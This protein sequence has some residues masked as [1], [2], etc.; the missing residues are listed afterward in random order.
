MVTVREFRKMG[1]PALIHRSAMVWFVTLLTFGSGLVNL[2]SVM[3]PALPER[4]AFLR[5]VFPLLFLHISR[6]MSLLVGFSL[7]IS[8]MNIYKR[9]KL[10]FQIVLI[11]S[12]FSIFFHLAKG[13]DYEEALFSAVLIAMLLFTRNEFTVKSGILDIHGNLLKL[14]FAGIIA[15]CYGIVGF[16]L[17]D[18]KEFGI[19][20]TLLDSIRR[21]FLFFAI[22]GDPSIHPHTHHAR[23]FLDSLYTIT[24]AFLVY[25]VVQVFRPVVYRYRTFP[26]EQAAAKSIVGRFGR[27]SQDFFKHWPDKSFFFSTNLEAFIA[28]R[29][30]GRYALALGD[31]VGPEEEMEGIIRSF[32]AMCRDNDWK[33]AFHQ[34][35]PDFLDTYRMLGFRKL[36][37]G[38]EAIVELSET[39]LHEHLMKKF[40]HVISRLEKKHIHAVYYPPP[41]P[42]DILDGAR[43]VSDEWLGIQGRRERGFTL[44]LFDPDYVRSTPVFTVADESE[45]IQAFANI[46]PSYRKG[47]TTIDLMRRREHAPGGVMDFLFVK[48]FLLSAGQGFERFTMGMAPMTGF[49]EREEATA[50]ERAIHTFFQHLNFIF[51]Y[52]G[53]RSYKAKFAAYWEPRYLIYQNALDLPGLALALNDISTVK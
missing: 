13:L 24:A 28:Y 6:L 35:L 26:L 25:A 43:E 11:L 14:T 45:R 52:R 50:E 17:L 41:V 34:T 30:G 51:S 48:L 19:N 39:Y 16:W 47:E 32:A 46:I 20:F 3:Y 15:L 37:I 8:S 36:K 44:G 1:K 9:K 49:R 29:V 18:P 40:H 2:I 7:M 5:E 31:P 38:D 33:P 27:S 53:L 42:D 10:A 12:L 22:I 23:W 21:A 4:R